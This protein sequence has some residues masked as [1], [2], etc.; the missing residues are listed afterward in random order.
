M[1][2]WGFSVGT[3]AVNIVDVLI[4]LI[5]L[6]AAVTGVMRGFV[7]GFSSRAGFLVG[8]LVALLFSKLGAALILDTFDLPPLWST[9]IAFI[10]LFI[11][12]YVL[13]MLVGSMLE[14]TLEA[15]HLDWLDRLLGLALGVFEALI[16]IAFIIYLLELQKVI[17][18]SVYLNRSVITIKVIK[19]FTPVGLALV[20]GLL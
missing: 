18:L 3:Y 10:L 7:M 14:R 8:F 5:A 15:F 20:K 1:A 12:G 2:E 11:V 16:M 19:P 13:V 4:L 6:L 17:D 9:L